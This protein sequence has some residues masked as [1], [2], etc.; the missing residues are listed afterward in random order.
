[1]SKFASCHST[2]SGKKAGGNGPHLT[3]ALAG[4]ANVGKSVIFNQLTGSH[5]TIGNWPGKTVD[6]A[7]GS[8]RHNGLDITIVDLPGIYSLSTFSMEEIVTRDYIAREKPDVIINVV[9]AP[10][11]ERNLFFT[12]QLMDMDVPIVVCLN[13]MDIAE[14]K[15]ITIDAKKL[16]TML[17]MPVVPTVALKGTGISRLIDRAAQAASEGN[18]R[19]NLR[20][21]NGVGS[22]IDELARLIE[23]EKLDLVYPARWVATKL[24]EDDAEIKALVNAKSTTIVEAAETMSRDIEDSHQQPR[25][26]VV[27]SERYALA[28]RITGVVQ[29][30]IT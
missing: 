2:S 27:A 12:L 1:M 28:S 8:L 30:Q 15:G 25:F 19:A 4:N 29:S 17:G 10:V 18:H 7:V 16:E 13:Q 23:S 20:L 9:G 3:I 21:G 6:R 26:A 11:L 24:I 22:C 5:Q 14:S